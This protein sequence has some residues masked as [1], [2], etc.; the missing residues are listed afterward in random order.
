MEKDQRRPLVEEIRDGDLE[1]REGIPRKYAKEQ[2]KY[3]GL[4]RYDREQKE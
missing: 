4:R 3:E 1:V 2:W